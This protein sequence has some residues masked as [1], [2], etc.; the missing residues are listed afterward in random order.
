[1]KQLPAPDPDRYL[2]PREFAGKEFGDEPA[3]DVPSGGMLEYWR[4]LQRRKG[5]VI[6]VA[7]L[8]MLAGFLL[9]LPQTPIYQARTVLEI[10]SL[11]EDFLHMKDVNP[12]ANS[13]GY[14]ASLELQTQVQM[15]QSR[16]L[17][18]RVIKK[19]VAEEKPFQAAPTRLQAWRSMLHLPE[20]NAVSQRDRAI[21]GAALS[22]RIRVQP[23]T[24]LI[25]ILSDSTNPRVAADFANTLTAEFIE[26]SLEARWQ[27]TEH[28]GEWLAR[29]MQD[30]K[31]KLEKSEDALQSYARMANLVI[32]DEKENAETLKLKQLQEELSK[33]QGERIARQ[34][35]Y[36]LASRASADSLA[37]VLDD[38]N[39][40]EVQGKLT[41]LRR[42]SAELT[43][44]LTASHPRVL[45][46]QAQIAILESAVRQERQN[47]VSRIRSDFES[48][49]RREK[50]LAAD[51]G[52]IAHTV[53]DQADKVTHYNTLKREVDTNRQ[54]YDSILQRVKEAGIASALRASNINVVD[55]AVAPALP[56]KPSLFNN[57]LMGL[58]AGMMLGIAGAVFL[59]RANR[60][61][62]EPG[63][64]AF[65][66]GVPEL[67][68]V[69]SAAADP[70]RGGGIMPFAGRNLAKSSKSMALVTLQSKPSAMAEAFRATLT[71]IMFS[72]QNGAAPG[73]LVVTSAAPK[74]GKTTLTTNL[75]VALAEIHKRVLLIDADLRRPSI[76]RFFDLDNNAGLVDL[77]RRQEPIAAPLNGFA[78]PSGIANLSILTSGKAADGDPSLLHSARLGELIKMVREEYDVVLIDTPPMLNMPDAR[79]IARHTDGVILVARANQTSRESIKDSHRRL[80]EDRTRVIGSVLNDWDPKHSNHYGY[81][82]YYDKYKHYYGTPKEQS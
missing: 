65:Y 30:L 22:L 76:H 62:Q 13:S 78:R 80:L 35:R 52:S 33:A 54:L 66:L 69:P 50:L 3:G 18:D 25:Q 43:S 23:N 9:T 46:V 44:S 10:Q 40:K 20:D 26:R 32:T 64:L 53:S 77:L 34:S 71:S 2:S 16:A 1:M 38:A 4:I 68:L 5:L 45:K 27:S 6:G 36:E 63:D 37:E 41:D 8:G 29:Q 74:E 39:L 31:V 81:Y 17:L 75:A 51:Y 82:R 48:S 60:T 42:Q 28:T 49:Q 61:I 67:G 59:D 79:V 19:M 12:N 15:L 7:M 24:R 58:L 47:I 14:D 70:T 21:R 72:G 55:P 57:T 11:N 73:V 56:Y